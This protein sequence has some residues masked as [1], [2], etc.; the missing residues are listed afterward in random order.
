M[1]VWLLKVWK[2]TAIAAVGLALATPASSE[3]FRWAAQTDVLSVDPQSS[4]DTQTRNFMRNVYERLTDLD[5]D[6][7]VGPR[8][9][10]KWELVNPTTWRFT[11]RPVVVFHDGSP[12]TADDVV[13]S[14]NRGNSAN[15][16]VK[17]RLRPIKSIS[18][19]DDLTVEVITQAPNPTLLIDLVFLEIY[20]K[21][22]AEKHDSVEPVSMASG[23]ANY[24][25]RNANGTGPVRVV[26]YQ[27][28]VKVVLAPNDKWWGEKKHNL[29]EA[30][31]TPI[32]AEAT[33]VAALLSGQVHLISPLP[34]QDV[35]R[36]KSNPNLMA[37]EGPESRVV[38][39]GLDQLSPELQYSNIKGKNPFKDIRVR[40]AFYQ[41]IDTDLVRDRIMNGAALSAA[42]LLT[43][44]SLGNDPL[45]TQRF[46]YDP[47]ASKR[48]LAEAGYPNGFE[49][50]LDCTVGRV[51]NDEKICQAVAAMLARV[52][53]KVDVFS[54]PSNLY[55]PKLSKRETSFFIGSWGSD[56]DPQPL[57]MM[58]MHSMKG[59]G[60]GM[61]NAGGYDSPKV[62]AL[63]SEIA[64]EMDPEKRQAMIKE[65]A[66]IHREDVAVI[67]LHQQTLAWGIRKGVT[68]RQR[69]DD[70]LDL[71]SVRV[72][73]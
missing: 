39:F 34:R 56:P 41:A 31:F 55:F 53:V 72:T 10:T 19:I 58:L 32:G 68:V 65:A 57:M 67:P 18:K 42:T 29:T 35:A 2:L 7:K 61:Y 49:V 45:A 11:L 5:G 22:W 6:M 73:R 36:I 16:D 25:S 54:V 8:L 59:D 23:K 26:D 50:T 38:Y 17:S 9:A 66:R 64:K 51:V 28:G 63:I 70:Y 43:A 69:A 44:S 62:D 14:F 40:R 37:L 30:I 3:T 47:E 33:R 13:F 20:S 12:F 24:A 48:L 4:G 21:S 46:P 15:S 71:N 1:T 52:G 60:A 27:P